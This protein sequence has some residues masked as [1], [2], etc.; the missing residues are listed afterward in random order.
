MKNINDNFVLISPDAGA[1]HKIEKIAQAIGY[2]GDIITCSKERD[3]EGNL[4]KTNVPLKYQINNGNYLE[5]CSKDFIIIDDIADGGR[6]FINIAKELK[7]QNVKGKIYLIV[8]HG[9]FSAGFNELSKYFDGIYCTNSY[10]DITFPWCIKGFMNRNSQQL[11][12]F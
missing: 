11:N 8:T 7:N 12:I 5:Y 9:I 6:T 1:S 10:S 3:T 4:T 2:K